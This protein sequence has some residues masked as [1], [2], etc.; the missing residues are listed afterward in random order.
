[1]GERGGPSLAP[2][3]PGPPCPA[4]AAWWP[5]SRLFG[6]QCFGLAME[7]PSSFAAPGVRREPGRGQRGQA[8]AGTPLPE[9]LA[10]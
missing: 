7:T 2:K 10:R 1:M 5:P 6:V 4:S 8:L 3:K 9:A